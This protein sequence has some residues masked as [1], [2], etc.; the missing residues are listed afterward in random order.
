M[1]PFLPKIIRESRF[2]VIDVEA[3]GVNQIKD[4]PVSVAIVQVDYGLVGVRAEIFI[5]PPFPIP[6][7]AT[8]IHGISDATVARARKFED[9]APDIVGIVGERCLLGYNVK[10]FDYPFL[11]R[12]MRELGP[13]WDWQRPVLDVLQLLKRV[14]PRPRAEG[15]TGYHQ[16]TAAAKRHGIDHGI[17]HN[18]MHD[19]RTTWSLFE[20]LTSAFPDL[21]NSAAPSEA[22]PAPS[23]KTN[24]FAAHVNM[25]EVLEGSVPDDSDIPF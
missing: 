10:G 13:D 19:C 7:E 4:W 25:R 11:R 3:T 12:R 21:G 23:T 1:I 22:P 15:V 5:K 17:A 9:V 6:A 16:L 20:R 18:A 8:E 2:A 24:S 14:D